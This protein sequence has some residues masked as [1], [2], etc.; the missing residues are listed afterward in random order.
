MARGDFFTAPVERLAAG[1]SG[2][3]HTAGQAIFVE[4][5]APGDRVL[6]RITETHK[7]W[8]RGELL[9]IREPSADRVVPACPLYGTCGGCSL[10]H[11]SYPVQL[12]EKEGI[13]RDALTRI[14]GIPGPFPIKTVPSPEYGYRNRVQFHA[15]P[16]E[17]RLGFKARK[18]GRIIPLTDCPIAD[19][20]L[21]RALAAGDIPLPHGRPRFAAYSRNKVLLCEGKDG[22]AAVRYLDRDIYLDAGLFFQGNAAVLEKLIPDLCALVGRA[23]GAAAAD[24]Y[25]GVGTFAAFLRDRFS[26]IDMVEMNKAA[27]DLAR[28]NVPGEGCQYFALPDDAWVRRAPRKGVYG[29]AVVDP[30]RQGLSPVTRQWLADAGPPL[31]AYVSCDPATLARDSASLLAGGYNLESVTFYDFYPQTAHIET[32]AVFNRQ[33]VSRE[34]A[35]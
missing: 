12:R 6:G 13:L 1:G 5:T 35:L 31:L 18:S 16:G 32:L 2:I 30:P 19:E 10:Q 17:G 11:L 4:Y 20:G 26:H 28:L 21:R 9:E 27:L 24:I 22:P 14:G 8:A 25:C 33:P 23:E 34:D 15:I 3:V 7:T 29:F